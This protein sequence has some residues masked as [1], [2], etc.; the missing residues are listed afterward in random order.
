[1]SSWHIQYYYILFVCIR[2]II[3]TCISILYK[4]AN[5][6]LRFRFGLAW[7]YHVL[8]NCLWVVNFKQGILKY[9]L[10]FHFLLKIYRFIIVSITTL[11]LLCLHHILSYKKVGLLLQVVIQLLQL[12]GI[13]S[14]LDILAV[15]G[16]QHELFI[17]G[18]GQ[19]CFK[20]I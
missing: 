15:A 2:S 1:M 16:L 12:S 9:M 14:Y 17:Y 11:P 5:Q 20:P 3:Y 4:V 13:S 6:V 7:F 19:S 10:L 18:A 8:Y